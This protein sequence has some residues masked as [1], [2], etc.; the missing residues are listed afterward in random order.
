[1]ISSA[2]TKCFLSVNKVHYINF[3]SIKFLFKC[4]TVLLNKLNEIFLSK[5][6]LKYIYCKSNQISD[7]YSYLIW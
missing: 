5:Q 7:I 4:C 1:M 3:I 6:G 2:D